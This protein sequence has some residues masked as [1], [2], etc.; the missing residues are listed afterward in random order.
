MANDDV[1]RTQRE[2]GEAFGVT[3]AAVRGWIRDKRWSL[4]KKPPWRIDR[5]RAWRRRWFGK[6]APDDVADDLDRKLKHGKL[7]KLDAEV[8][9]I[10]GDNVPREVF[11]L[12]VTGLAELFVRSLVNLESALPQQLAG[13]TAPECAEV[14]AFHLDGVRAQLVGLADDEKQMA[15]GNGRP[16]RR[17]G[18]PRGDR[19]VE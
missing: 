8:S 13:K 2:L 18:K 16:K 14:L 3:D 6:H 5:V 7:A 1:A 12:A 19:R 17:P 10:R 15:D 11:E 4:K 9:K